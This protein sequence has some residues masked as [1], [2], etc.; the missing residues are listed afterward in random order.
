[1]CTYSINPTF[2]GI[3][4]IFETI[5][6]AAIREAMKN[7][8]FRWHSQKKLWYAKNTEERLSL[9]K[10][11]SGSVATPATPA[12]PV[13]P[14]TP[15]EVVSKYG[16]K[17]GDILTCSWGYSMTIVEFYKVTKIIS[18]SK[19]EIVEVGHKIIEADRGGGETLMPDI[20]NEIG[21]HL[22]KL[23]VAGHYDDWHV[24]INSSIYL[25]KWDG[26][27]CYQNT[28]D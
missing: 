16:I 19:I 3:E 23:V 27:P 6:T 22:Q 7:A 21:E 25:H 4:I 11:L 10:R 13:A 1:M 24:K 2:N 12:A 17:A 14:A 26:R 28:Y 18:A 15:A 20:T 9:A 5:P 8:G